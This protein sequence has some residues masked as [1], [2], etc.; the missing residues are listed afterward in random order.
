[1]TAAL[2][3]KG[4]DAQADRLEQDAAQM[5]EEMGLSLAEAEQ[6]VSQV[7]EKRGTLP[8]RCSGCG[9]SLVPD[10]VEWHDAHTAEC[11][12]CGTVTKDF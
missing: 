8:A 6:R 4:H 12:Y 3:K 1:M 9:A 10:E 2:R 7:I 11:C 5:L